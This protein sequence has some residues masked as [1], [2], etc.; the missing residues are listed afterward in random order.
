[1]AA[2]LAV[3][4]ATGHERELFAQ[5]RAKKEGLI[6]SNE[7]LK[8]PGSVLLSHTVTRAVPSALEGLTTEFG[9]DIGCFPSAIAAGKRKTCFH[10]RRAR[11]TIYAGYAHASYS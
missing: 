4:P 1:M 6:L 3:A 2:G 5:Q 8:N 10:E 7:A 11:S 9:M